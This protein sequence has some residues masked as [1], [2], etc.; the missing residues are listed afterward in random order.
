MQDRVYL[1]TDA[2]HLVNASLKPE[3]LDVSLPA[4]DR[5]ARVAERRGV[6]TIS[7][8]PLGVGGMLVK[9]DVGYTIAIREGDSLARRNFS[10][11]HEIG[12]LLIQEHNS[13]DRLEPAAKHR[14][15]SSSS[16]SEEKLCDQIAAEILMPELAFQEDAWMEGWSLVSLRT[17]ARKYST[18]IPATARRLVDLMPE[19]SL[20]GIWRIQATGDRGLLKLAGAH[21]SNLR[22]GV[23]SSVPRRRSWLVARAFHNEGIQRG[24]APVVDK[25]RNVRTPPDVPAE[26]L[27]WG[28]GEYQRVLVHYYPERR[29]TD[30]E[31]ALSGGSWRWS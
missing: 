29:L 22:Y 9:S 6:R 14:F 21:S 19:T 30:D 12:H 31:A 18:S 11:A 23:P 17:L 13:S 20:I 8:G 3:E 1:T 15:A 26:A 27:A 24:F 5:L 25:K 28:H 2:R 4:W 16:D 7:V 10:L